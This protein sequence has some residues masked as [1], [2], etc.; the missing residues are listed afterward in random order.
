MHIDHESDHEA[1]LVYNTDGEESLEV[2]S[3]LEDVIHEIVS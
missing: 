3:D 1:R 2:P